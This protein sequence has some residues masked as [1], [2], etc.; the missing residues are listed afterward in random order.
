VVDIRANLREDERRRRDEALL[1][2]LQEQ[3][4]ELRLL[5]RESAARHATVDEAQRKLAETVEGFAA[6]LEGVRAEARGLNEA[7]IVEI[8][9]LRGEAEEIDRRFQAAV[10]PI[11]HL[12]SQL[13]ELAAQTR[14]RFQ[15]LGQD[16]HRFGELQAQIDRLPSQIERTAEIARATRDEAAGLRA[17]ID[18]IRKDWQKV[19]DAV[20][21]VEQDAR[22]RIG[23]L[24][25]RLA[26][27]N[28]RI[29]HLKE[30]LP[31]LDA[32]IA[33]VRGEL[34]QALPRL[35]ELAKADLELQ[36][37]IDRGAALDFD[38]HVQAIKKADEVREA[39]E[40][41]VRLVERLNDTRF[42]STM[43]RFDE[44]EEADRALGH[45]I[46]LLAVRLDEL[47]DQ[48]A[49]IRLEMRRLE[50]MRIR[51]RL[52][53]AQQEAM[54]FSERLAQIQAELLAD[55]DEDE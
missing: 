54:A 47:R 15:E 40:E 30:E 21:M 49:A 10:G 44:L 11:P 9:R 27:T 1:G 35:D 17:E 19:G 53:Q 3:V 46:T 33:R 28:E 31:P 13:G 39:I 43:A 7:R 37:G 14:A 34:H 22:R 45:R 24:T 8:T 38:R 16:R 51:V 12:Q 42:S 6:Q 52:E 23:E 29:D 4:E 20:G 18:A 32:Q 48:D 25:T 41:R 55:D 2:R 50:E 26:E 36:E 5:L